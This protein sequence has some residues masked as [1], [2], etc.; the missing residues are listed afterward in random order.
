M[1]EICMKNIG[2]IIVFCAL[3]ITATQSFGMYGN[4]F[5]EDAAS[6]AEF[7]K[8]SEIRI[9]TINGMRVARELSQGIGISARITMT[10]VGIMLANK[11]YSENR[12]IKDVAKIIIG[13]TIALRSLNS[14]DMYVYSYFNRKESSYGPLLYWKRVRE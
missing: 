12:S 5:D 10:V 7:R 4:P 13:M 3:C 8:K 14:F 11:I 2:K 9:P 6:N 1:K